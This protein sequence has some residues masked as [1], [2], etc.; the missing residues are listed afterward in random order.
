MTLHL[1]SAPGFDFDMTSYSRT[2]R[3]WE[4]ATTSLV[5]TS[6]HSTKPSP[7]GTQVSSPMLEPVTIPPLETKF[8]PLSRRDIEEVNTFVL[9]AGF[10]RSGH[11]VVGSLMD[12]HPDI[13]I[14]HEFNV[15]KNVRKQLKSSHNPLALFNSL[16][17]NS[18][19][20]AVKGWRS[21]KWTKK[22][23]T[24]SMS[25]NSWQ[26]RVRRLR[27]IGD[28]SGALTLHEF[29]SDPS[30]C[31]YLVEKLRDTLDISVKAIHV[32][33]NPYD[34]IATKFLY[35][36]RKKDTFTI[37]RTSS[38]IA[39]FQKSAVGTKHIDDF[40]ELVSTLHKMISDCHLPVL[41]VHLTELISQPKSVMRDICDF[42]GVEC[43]VDYLET[44]AGKLFQSLSKTRSL[45]KWS[46]EQRDVVAQ[47]S[48]RF[49]EFSRYSY[50]CDC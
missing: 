15:L 22:G 38:E 32:V 9:F 19:S 13:I 1:F 35:D 33:R 12:A 39:S 10:G 49:T 27:V 46:Q 4:K 17:R 37:P 41:D 44:C 2:C 8:T 36:T 30:K 42:V 26:G 11:S 50:D 31:L 16:Y 6:P 25:Q 43:S 7:N 23:Y 47:N 14:A 29:K 48:S 5:T 24:L 18:Y 20:S 45:V 34:N 21:K 3:N 28:K 40:F